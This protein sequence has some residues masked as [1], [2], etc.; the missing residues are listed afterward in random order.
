MK[1]KRNKTRRLL[2]RRTPFEERKRGTGA[3][4]PWTLKYVSITVRFFI[5]GLL[6]H[7]LLLFSPKELYNN[8]TTLSL[9][10]ITNADDQHTSSAS[11]LSVNVDIVCGSNQLSTKFFGEEWFHLC[12]GKFLESTNYDLKRQ[13]DIH[14]VQIGAHVGF[15][16]N[17]P[18]AIGA[19][20]FLSN[21]TEETK[22]RFHWTFVEPSPSNYE[23]LKENL[24][25]RSNLL[26]DLQSINAAV[27]PDGTPNTSSMVFHSFSPDINPDTGYDSRS[28][29]QLPA[30]I[31]Q[32]SGF[33]M[34]PLNFNRGVFSKKGLNMMDYIVD[35]HVTVYPYSDLMNH[36]TGGME[37]QLVIIDTEGFDCNIVLGISNSSKYLPPYLIFEVHQCGDKKQPAFEYLR[38][39]GYIVKKVKSTQNA[40]AIRSNYLL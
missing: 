5:F 33:N 19:T 26:C 32:V 12:N 22:K 20:T 15:E 30:F 11:D 4:G 35:T 14:I 8:S 38:E 28:G 13:S 24:H 17:D 36:I 23:R 27:V 25:N 18:F 7:Q 31:T 29:K 10:L 1:K 39:L 9:A 21:L 6:L 2:S 40:I 34:G 16:R 37:P 3:E